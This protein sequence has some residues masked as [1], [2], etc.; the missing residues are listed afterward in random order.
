MQGVSNSKNHNVNATKPSSVDTHCYCG[1]VYYWA[2]VVYDEHY[3]FSGFVL[4]NPGDGTMFY[5]I[6]MKLTWQ[7]DGGTAMVECVI[8]T[9]P[10]EGVSV[11]IGLKVEQGKEYCR[12]TAKNS[13][14]NVV[15]SSQKYTEASTKPIQ[16]NYIK[17]KPPTGL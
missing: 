10:M 15:I 4:V 9:E 2:R 16:H 11:E 13:K 17:F 7:R 3:G 6:P 8:L 1:H 5:E 12:Y 14:T